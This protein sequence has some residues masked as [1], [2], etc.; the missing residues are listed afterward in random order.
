MCDHPYWVTICALCGISPEYA[1]R[2]D[3][4]GHPR[5]DTVCG[6]CGQKR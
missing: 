5:W 4:C 3:P 1:K 2:G 6:E